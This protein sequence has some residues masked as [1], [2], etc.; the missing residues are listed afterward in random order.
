M[1]GSPSRNGYVTPACLACGEPLPLGRPRTTCSDACRQAAWRRRH[2]P[3]VTAPVLP[4][5]RPR[6]AHTV[7]ECDDCGTRILGEQ[8]CDCGKFMRRLGTGGLCPCCGEPI[9]VE[10]LLGH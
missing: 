2:Q 7:Y 1:T 9:I 5:R 10:D 6:K 8:R 4:P 3:D